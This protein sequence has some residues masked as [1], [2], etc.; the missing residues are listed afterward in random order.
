V[1]RAEYLQL[2][3]FLAGGTV[4]LT[5]LFYVLADRRPRLRPT[6]LPH[7]VH[8]A[9]RAAFYNG[10]ALGAILMAAIGAIFYVR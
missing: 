7:P 9:D 5:R 8:D 4:A 1:T 2:A 3:F 10:M 6:Q